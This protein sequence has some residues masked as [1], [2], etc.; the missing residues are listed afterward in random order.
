M[1][2]IFFVQAC[3]KIRPLRQV[4]GLEQV[5][6]FD[7]VRFHVFRKKRAVCNWN[8]HHGIELRRGQTTAIGDGVVRHPLGFQPTNHLGEVFFI[9]G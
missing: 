9:T 7:A 4:G 1:E 5:G 6:F 8:A 2:H 3:G